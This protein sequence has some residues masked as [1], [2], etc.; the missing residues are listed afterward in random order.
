MGRLNDTL[1]QIFRSLLMLCDSARPHVEN[2]TQSMSRQV[3]SYISFI[4][5]TYQHLTVAEGEN[6]SRL[7]FYFSLIVHINNTFRNR[8]LIRFFINELYA[9][10]I[11][12]KVEYNILR[13][14][15]ITGITS[16]VLHITK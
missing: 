7:C 10:S 16:F 3:G 12:I 15:N 4:I 11:H 5:Q 1:E 13:I 2:R 9:T 14:K 6:I 8:I